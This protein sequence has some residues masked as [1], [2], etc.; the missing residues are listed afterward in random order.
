MSKKTI[1]KSLIASVIVSLL[2]ALGLFLY[3]YNKFMTTG[4]MLFEKVISGGEYKAIRG[5]GLVK[6][7]IYSMGQNSGSHSN[8]LII[9]SDLLKVF[10]PLVVVFFIIFSVI[11]YLIEKKKS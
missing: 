1:L 7:T 2:S 3:N 10:I 11:G 8:V 9:Y 6:E 4:H 5:Y